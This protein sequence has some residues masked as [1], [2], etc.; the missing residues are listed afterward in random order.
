M[1]DTIGAVLDRL[2]ARQGDPLARDAARVIRRLAEQL[3]VAEAELIDADFGRMANAA[4]VDQ[5][6]TFMARRAAPNKGAR[7]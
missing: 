7:R 1:T 3:T 4:E 5:L 6:R 2:D